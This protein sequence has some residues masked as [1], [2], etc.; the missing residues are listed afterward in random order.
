MKEFFESTYGDRI[1]AV[2]DEWYGDYDPA[3]VDVLGEL[4]KGG[5][6]LELGIGSGRIAFPLQQRG[7][8]IQGIDASKAMIAK[9]KEKSGGEDIQ[10]TLGNFADVAVEGQFKLIYV[11]F[12]TFFALGTQEEQLQCFQKVANRLTPDGAFLIEAFVP[13]MARYIDQQTVRVSHLETDEVHLEASQLDMLNQQ[14]SS[15]HIVLSEVGV[16]MYPVKLRYAWP[17]ELDLMARLANLTLKERW[18]SWGKESFTNESK[19]H[20]SLYGAV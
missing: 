5:R 4:A 16:K 11:V 15:Q 13:D 1:A 7:I 6:A 8:E 2:Y 17:A 12:N 14:V 9:L 18:G 3:I 20:I 19:R 10:V